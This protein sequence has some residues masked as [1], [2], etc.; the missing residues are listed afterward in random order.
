MGS[1]DVRSVVS[2]VISCFLDGLQY[3][4]GKEEGRDRLS[5]VIIHCTGQGQRVLNNM[6]GF[7]LGRSSGLTMDSPGQ[8]MT[9]ILE[10]TL[11]SNV[12]LFQISCHRRYSLARAQVDPSKNP[13]TNQSLLEEFGQILNLLF[14]THNLRGGDNSGDLEWARCLVHGGL[15]FLQ[16]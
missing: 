15:C 4:K 16:L 9:P 11:L 6:R 13:N 8:V 12:P 3:S 2:A 14:C 1:E 10:P 5:K 7:E